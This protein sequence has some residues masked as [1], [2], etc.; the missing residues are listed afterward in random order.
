MYIAII[1]KTIMYIGMDDGCTKFMDDSLTMVPMYHACRT[2]ENFGDESS[3]DTLMRSYGGVD[4]Q[5]KASFPPYESTHH[6]PPSLGIR[7][8][9]QSLLMPILKSL[10]P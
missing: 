5:A 9:V 2:R 10:S 3:L 6:H 8:T 1:R 7:A 4:L